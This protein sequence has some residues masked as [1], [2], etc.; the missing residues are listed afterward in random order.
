MSLLSWLSDR[1][2]GDADANE[3]APERLP[4]ADEVVLLMHAGG[5]PEA[6][7][8]RELLGGDN[9]HALVKNSSALSA[10]SPG[11]GPFGGWELWVLRRDLRRA[12]DLL[13]MGDDSA[14]P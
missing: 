3:G 12:R 10:Y 2:F 1:L 14:G 8:L 13:G 11:P 6:L 9:I 7:M 4:S 5:E